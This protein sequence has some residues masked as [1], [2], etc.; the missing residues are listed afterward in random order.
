M[1]VT[2]QTLGE[3]SAGARA[4]PGAAPTSGKGPG[5]AGEP[6]A[7]RRRAWAAD[8]EGAMARLPSRLSGPHHCISVVLP[9]ETHARSAK[10]GV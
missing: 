5:L 3:A 8:L 2:H 6:T 1:W 10:E 4:G 9:T 7:E